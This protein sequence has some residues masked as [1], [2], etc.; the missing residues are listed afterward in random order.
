[1]YFVSKTAQVELKSGRVQAPALH[2]LAA[3]DLPRRAHRRA[4]GVAAQ[5]EFES[6]V[7]KQSIMFQFQAPS[8][9]RFQHGFHRVNPHRPAMVNGRLGSTW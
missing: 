3:H 6:K 2:S 7:W 9:K 5:I 8:S 1:M 4:H